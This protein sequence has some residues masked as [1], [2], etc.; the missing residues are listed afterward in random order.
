MQEKLEKVT[1]CNSR[2]K[3]LQSVS[4]FCSCTVHMETCRQW[5]K[6]FRQY[7]QQ[8]RVKNALVIKAESLKKSFIK[9]SGLIC[10]SG[11]HPLAL[12]KSFICVVLLNSAFFS[13]A[14]NSW[15][16]NS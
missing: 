13:I 10:L 8:N 9:G 1:W 4:S 14:L 15:L 2:K 11:S 16:R 7:G 12:V 5:E 3:K 6:R